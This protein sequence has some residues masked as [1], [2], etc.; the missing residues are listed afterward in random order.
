MHRRLT[1]SDRPMTTTDVNKQEHIKNKT[2]L[3]NKLQKNISNNVKRENEANERKNKKYSVKHSHTQEMAE[4]AY[5]DK[6][7]SNFFNTQR[8]FHSEIYIFSTLPAMKPLTT[9][10]TFYHKLSNIIRLT[11][12]TIG[13]L[14]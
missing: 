4:R 14:R 12:Q 8:N 3:S 13:F 9:A 2:K 11:T 7:H 1:H 5:T 6:L 10:I